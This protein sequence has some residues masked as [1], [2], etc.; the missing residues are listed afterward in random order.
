MRAPAGPSGQAQK[1]KNARRGGRRSRSARGRRLQQLDPGAGVAA[2]HLAPVQ[3]LVALGDDGE[4]ALGLPPAGRIQR[5]QLVHKGG[6]EEKMLLRGVPGSARRCRRPGRA[7]GPPPGSAARPGS[8]SAAPPR[9]R[10]SRPAR[11]PSRPSAA[12][13]RRCPGHHPFHGLARRGR[14]LRAPPGD[15]GVAGLHAGGDLLRLR[16]QRGGAEAMEI[17]QMG[18]GHG[19]IVA[20]GAGLC[21]D[22][23]P[24]TDPR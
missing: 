21:H 22:G 15:A 23:E 9:W 6:L 13:S 10:K 11:S 3:H 24:E 17:E 7:P 18:D 20:A 5:A 1:G 19:A 12:A 16:R 8:R 14:E 2:G 4:K